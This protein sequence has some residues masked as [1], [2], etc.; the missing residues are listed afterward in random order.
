MQVKDI[1][2]CAINSTLESTIKLSISSQEILFMR[3]SVKVDML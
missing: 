1:E 2:K 3:V